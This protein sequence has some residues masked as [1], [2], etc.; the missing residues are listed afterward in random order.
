M[1][2]REETYGLS[3]GW[4]DLASVYGPPTDFLL[5]G[6]LG[7]L[8]IAAADPGH[9]ATESGTCFLNGV[10]FT[11][12]EEGVVALHSGPAFTDPFP[13]KLAV[14][15]FLEDFLHGFFGTGVDDARPTADVP[16]FGGL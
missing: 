9:E 5:V 12:F 13:G 11:F 15:N 16:V 2:V 14:T 3:Q 1:K 8:E 7:S 4:E 6:G 10:F